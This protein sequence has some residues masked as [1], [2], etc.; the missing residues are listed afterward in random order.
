MSAQ[1]EPEFHDPGELLDE[2]DAL[3]REQ[4]LLQRRMEMLAARYRA[5]EG[6]AKD[7]RFDKPGKDRFEREE[8]GTLNVRWAA[9]DLTL[10]TGYAEY[11]VRYLGRARA[12]AVKVREYPQPQWDRDSALADYRETGIES[13][14]ERGR[15]R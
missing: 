13:S 9:E 5:V 4:M 10:A 1:R 15:S 7:G 11:G 2:L 14:A 6:P 12:S 8:Y 3:L